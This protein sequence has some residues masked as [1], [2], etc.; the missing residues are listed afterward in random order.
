MAGSRNAVEMHNFFCINCGK[1]GIPVWRKI[2]C[3]RAKN[4]RKALYCT[5]CK[6]TINHIEVT[7][8]QEAEQFKLDFERG[9]F[10]TEA[11]ASVEFDRRRKQK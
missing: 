1:Q 6:M 2:G 3:R 9:K 7:T 4:H 11:A 5:N 8:K 10:L